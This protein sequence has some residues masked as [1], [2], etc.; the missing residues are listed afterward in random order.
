MS[1]GVVGIEK[2]FL[3]NNNNNGNNNSGKNA[4]DCINVDTNC[5]LK[6]IS[7]FKK[8][9]KRN[10]RNLYEEGTYID[11]VKMLNKRAKVEG[12]LDTKSEDD[13]ILS[14]E[15]EGEDIHITSDDSNENRNK[16]NVSDDN[17]NNSVHEVMGNEDLPFCEHNSNG[18]PMRENKICA[19]DQ[20]I[21]EENEKKMTQEL[22]M[23]IDNVLESIRSCNEIGEAKRIMTSI[24]NNCI[25]NNFVYVENCKDNPIFVKSHFDTLHKEKRI[26]KSALK[27]QYQMIKQLQKIIDNQKLELKKKN[28][29]LNQIKAKVHQYF[30][31]VS[32]PNRETFQPYIYPD[33]Y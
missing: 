10:V 18:T 6:D 11:D 17:K 30:Y 13:S 19:K 25:R 12:F 14:E 16:K 2:R 32:N 22:D 23:C 24:L 15:E 33:V 21:I 8:A 1:A 28:D 5:I 20:A 9:R 27:W 26:L 4:Y 3:V 7:A 31:E 29:E